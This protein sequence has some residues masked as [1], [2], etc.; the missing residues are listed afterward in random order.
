MENGMEVNF[1]WYLAQ[2]LELPT[3]IL[4]LYFGEDPNANPDPDLECYFDDEE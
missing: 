4:D 3:E 2:G 1:D